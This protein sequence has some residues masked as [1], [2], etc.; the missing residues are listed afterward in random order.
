MV[1]EPKDLMDV[2]KPDERDEAVAELFRR[3]GLR[4]EQM[5]L[6]LISSPVAS[7][8]A[9]AFA[10]WPTVCEY[11]TNFRTVGQLI[12]WRSS[13]GPAT[14]RNAI[15]ARWAVFNRSR[16]SGSSA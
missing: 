12:P 15:L 4:P 10:F 14:F 7:V 8:N 11:S 3:V 6:F 1:P 2:G 16:N 9:S 5:A 13:Y